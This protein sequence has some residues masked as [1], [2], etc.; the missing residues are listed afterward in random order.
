MCWLPQVP[1]HIYSVRSGWQHSALVSTVDPGRVKVTHCSQLTASVSVALVG[2]HFLAGQSELTCA[3]HTRQLRSQSQTVCFK[4]I[5]P[6]QTAVADDMWGWMRK[7]TVE[8]QR[9]RSGSRDGDARIK[10]IP[11]FVCFFVFVCNIQFSSL[12]YPSVACSTFFYFHSALF[13][14]LFLFLSL[15][16]WQWRQRFP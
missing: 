16:A 15:L 14:F 8:G 1:V 6:L 2:R 10:Q 4:N 13:S 5:V 9:K 7:G 11:I 3:T 12:L